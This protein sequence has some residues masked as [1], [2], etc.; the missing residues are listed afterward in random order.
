MTIYFIVVD[1]KVFVWVTCGKVEYEVVMEG[2]GCCGVVELSKFSFIDT[3]FE[4]PWS[5]DEE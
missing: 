3:K 2:V 5:Y 1:V 4:G